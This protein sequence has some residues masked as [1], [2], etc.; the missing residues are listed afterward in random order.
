MNAN[1]TNLRVAN[2]DRHFA[3]SLLVVVGLSDRSLLVIIV[4]VAVAVIELEILLDPTA[5]QTLPDLV[6]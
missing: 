6:R 1:E 2:C 3:L 5:N 4:A